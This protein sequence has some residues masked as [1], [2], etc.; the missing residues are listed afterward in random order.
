MGASSIGFDSL[1]IAILIGWIIIALISIIIFSIFVLSMISSHGKSK[2]YPKEKITR[3]KLI[4]LLIIVAIHMVTL[5]TFFVID[6]IRRY[7]L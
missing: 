2:D 6:H 3:R 7:Y 5:I 4:A 1:W